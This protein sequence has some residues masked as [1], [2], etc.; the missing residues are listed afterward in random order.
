NAP[1]PKVVLPNGNG[2]LK[3][4]EVGFVTP[5]MEGEVVQFDVREMLQATSARKFFSSNNRD[6][7]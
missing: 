3:T 2:S 5:G 1:I 6:G 7:L 4:W